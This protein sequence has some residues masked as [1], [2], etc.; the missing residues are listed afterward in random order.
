VAVSVSKCEP[1][2]NEQPPAG[3]G[4]DGEKDKGLN[5]CQKSGSVCEAKYKFSEQ[6]VLNFKD[7]NYNE[8][9]SSGDLKFIVE[10]SG[11]KCDLNKFEKTFARVNIDG[12]PLFDSSVEA[13][14]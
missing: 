10:L 3:P 4:G 8:V 14:Q 1:V 5:K 12:R 6:L 11:S 2:K 7:N 13:N 9:V